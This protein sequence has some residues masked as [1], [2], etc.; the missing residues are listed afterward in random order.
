MSS[1]IEGVAALA[2][3]G[4]CVIE[5]VLTEEEVATAVSYFR[6]WFSSHPQI[7]AVY[8]KMQI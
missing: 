7:G 5:D 4:F 6:E 1:Y 8:N 3:K 2:E